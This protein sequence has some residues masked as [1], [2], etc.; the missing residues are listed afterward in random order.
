MKTVEAILYLSLLTAIGL[1]G[2]DS[3]DDDG[4]A[5]GAM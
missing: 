3:D 4:G 2:C 1:L 5:G